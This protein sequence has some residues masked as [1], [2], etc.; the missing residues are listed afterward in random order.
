MDLTLRRAEAADF[1][2]LIQHDQR[3][4]GTTHS[5][6]WIA[7]MR[8]LLDLE[9]FLFVEDAGRV[10]G[11]TGSV[12]FPMGVPGGQLDIEGVT[13]VSVLP[14]HRRRGVLRMLMAAQL[15]TMTTAV[16]ALTASQGTL[17]GRY[18]YGAATET[19]RIRIDKRFARFRPEAPDPG[20]VRMIS[21]REARAH[22]P[23]VQARWAV[24]TPGSVLRHDVL[25]DLFLADPEED[26]DGGTALFHLAH[27]DGYASY[28]LHHD[29][30]TLV[31]RDLFAATPEA[32]AALWRVLLSGDFVSHLETGVSPP[33][34]PLGFLLTDPRLVETSEVRDGVWIRVLDV[35]AALTARRY[36][37]EVDVVLDVEGSRYHVTGGPDGAECTP[38]AALPDVTLGHSALGTLYLGGHRAT[39]LARA[40]L[41]EGDAHRIDTA[42][43]AD[44]P[45]MHGTGF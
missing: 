16:A 33:G 20:G 38:T 40:G 2:A 45:P 9:R 23:E 30:S 19:R 18:G 6:A 8:R 3:G 35:P 21:A 13:W 41:V 37:A 17:Y 10:V 36:T 42:F 4:F 5:E 7:G 15:E 34:D 28:R 26:R 32:H 1:D 25:W 39:T 29:R 27:P 11:V 24:G 44:R 12:P 43:L 22:A 14:T 31:V